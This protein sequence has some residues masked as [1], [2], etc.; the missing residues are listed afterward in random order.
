MRK[1]PQDD[2]R[3]LT[4]AHA[5]PALSCEIKSS[6]TP[7]PL[8]PFPVRDTL[9][10]P[11]PGLTLVHAHYQVISQPIS[12]QWLVRR[13]RVD[14]CCIYGQI[15][16]HNL[17]SRNCALESVLGNALAIPKYPLTVLDTL[18]HTSSAVTVP[19]AYLK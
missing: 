17:A 9:A 14:N 12:A 6:G 16:L 18:F 10:R 13:E 5:D 4:G 2:W 1:P 11:Y 8:T 3:M 7:T 19:L 15:V